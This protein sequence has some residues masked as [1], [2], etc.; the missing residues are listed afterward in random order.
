MHIRTLN[1]HYSF[2]LLLLLRPPGC[3]VNHGGGAAISLL[4]IILV[5]PLMILSVTSMTMMLLLLLTIIIRSRCLCIIALLFTGKFSQNLKCC[6]R[7]TWLHAANTKSECFYQQ[8]TMHA[9]TC[10]H[11]WHSQM[12]CHFPSQDFF[13]VN[14]PLIFWVC[15]TQFNT[16]AKFK[17][18][19]C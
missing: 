5:L 19:N 4:V 2:I 14:I 12:R 9:C 1:K 11:D 18:Y 17:P 3:M 8:Q 16:L 7:M 15:G 13:W 10:M 6:S